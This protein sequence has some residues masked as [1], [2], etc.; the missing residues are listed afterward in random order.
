MSNNESV[1][2]ESTSHRQRS[3]IGSS[4]SVRDFAEVQS[5]EQLHQED[6]ADCTDS[7]I[8]LSP[9]SAPTKIRRRR[10]PIFE[11]LRSKR[12]QILL[13]HS[14][15]SGGSANE[16]SS[17]DKSNTDKKKRSLVAQYYCV[18]TVPSSPY[19]SDGILGVVPIE[20]PFVAT[21]MDTQ[22]KSKTNRLQSPLPPS[23]PTPSLQKTEVNGKSHNNVGKVVN[24]VLPGVPTYEEDWARDTHD[25]FNLIVLVPVTVLNIM[26]W[27]WDILLSALSTFFYSHSHRNHH[28]ASY[29]SY[30]EEIVYTVQSAWTGDWF[31]VFF[32]VT[33]A[34]FIFDLLWIVALPIC[35][36]SPS[37][38]I[39]H[40]IAVLIYILIPYLHP[41]VRYCMGACMT[42]EIN[43]WFLIARRV[44]NKQGFPPWTLIELNSWLSIRVKVISIFFYLT[45]ICIRCI[46]Y[47]VLL[48]P[49]YQHW[50]AYTK[51]T[52]T[53]FNIL[54]PSI[55]L[56]GAFCLLN[57]KWS[58]ELLM[59]KLRYFRR[60][61]ILRRHHRR[62]TNGKAHSSTNYPTSYADSSVSSG[63]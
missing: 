40:H 47:P 37:V 29:L 54:L 39:Q 16:N 57:L 25:Y 27:N 4:A 24:V 9:P 31:D 45:W 62:A 20:G 10:R 36:K 13:Q 63:L 8:P 22:A 14:S 7:V 26:N 44:F 50:Y 48:I 51:V 53:P 28:H 2:T 55:P 12:R 49:F 17:D 6:N 42:V 21:D 43:T 33:A 38:I 34:Y 30:L 41:N 46:L 56:H 3:S 18:D 32:F 58:Y 60:Q 23:T 5:T 1:T 19:V 61:R 35:V 15:N 52:G 59:S 11:K